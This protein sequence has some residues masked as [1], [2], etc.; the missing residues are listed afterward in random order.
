MPP[1]HVLKDPSPGRVSPLALLQALRGIW[2]EGGR[3]MVVEIDHETGDLMA[4]TFEGEPVDP[5]V[6]ITRGTMLRPFEAG[7]KGNQPF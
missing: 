1:S 5:C 6:V 7:A 3:E 4:C 2:D